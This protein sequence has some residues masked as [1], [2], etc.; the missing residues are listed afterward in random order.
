MAFIASISDSDNFTIREGR[1][2]SI[3]LNL[4]GQYG[5]ISYSY[6]IRYG[7]ADSTDVSGAS[8]SG[9]LSISS[10]GTITRTIPISFRALTDRLT[11][12]DET[13][14][15]SVTL[16]GATFQGGSSSETVV[17]TIRDSG[18]IFG[19]SRSETLTGTNGSEQIF[20]YRG[21]DELIGR[22]GADTLSGG[23][24]NDLL[25]G[26][27]RND[28]L[29]AGNGAD[30]LTGG[31]GS[32]RLNGDR[33]ND[34]LTGGR[35]ADIFVFNGRFGEDTISDFGVGKDRIDLTDFDNVENL[36]DLKRNHAEQDSD[37]LII[38]IGRKG[39]I[40]LL[41]TDI[42]D[43]RARSFDFAE[44]PS[45]SPDDIFAIPDIEWPF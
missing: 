7:T 23:D 1:G 17:I 33:G 31:G 25:N 41:D 43:L 10:T 19:S 28:H 22:G 3:D 45:S 12:E 15:V 21:A 44:A 5:T 24:G 35:N 34:N 2:G 13:F 14:S 4:T 18:D 37:D 36:R 38:T 26:G 11:E 42:S 40:T 39:S 8:G 20:G 30:T 9:V 32:D 29:V 6:S 16:S 27:G